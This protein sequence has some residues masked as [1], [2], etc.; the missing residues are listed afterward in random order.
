MKRMGLE[1]KKK[2]GF[3]KIKK[4]MGFGKWKKKMS[5][6]KIKKGMG[7]GKWKKKMGFVENEKRWVLEKKGRRIIL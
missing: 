1:N 4:G 7:F 6:W 2:M 3:W 5:F